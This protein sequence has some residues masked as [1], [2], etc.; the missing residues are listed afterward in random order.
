MSGATGAAG[1]SL[2]PAVR[3]ACVLRFLLR[4]RYRGRMVHAVLKRKTLKTPAGWAL[5]VVVR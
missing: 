5:G 4:L 2:A 3:F 1:G